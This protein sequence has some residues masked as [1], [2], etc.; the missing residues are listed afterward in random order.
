MQRS[1]SHVDQLSAL[2]YRAPKRKLPSFAH[3][4]DPV[5]K[6]QK[7]LSE[8]IACKLARLRSKET[9]SNCLK[10]LLTPSNIKAVVFSAMHNRPCRALPPY[11]GAADKLTLETI[12]NEARREVCAEGAPFSFDATRYKDCKKKEEEVAAAPAAR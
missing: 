11:M 5:Q 3:Q 10:R 9:T 4:Q 12:I 6:K 7:S 1:L 2:A 8:L